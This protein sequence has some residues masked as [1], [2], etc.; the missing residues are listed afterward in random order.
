[1]LLVVKVSP[2]LLACTHIKV[3]L[4]GFKRRVQVLPSEQRFTRAIAD[5]VLPF[6]S[7]PT[8]TS[9]KENQEEDTDGT[10][11]YSSNDTFVGHNVRAPTAFKGVVNGGIPV[12]MAKAPLRTAA[13]ED[14]L[15]TPSRFL[16]R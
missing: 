7:S 8:S 16:T 4:N 14:R 11:H 9:S 13:V 2:K 5:R 10:W 6:R 15:F 12:A 3:F 1:M